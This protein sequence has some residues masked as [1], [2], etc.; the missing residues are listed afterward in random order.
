MLSGRR[1]ISLS[2]SDWFVDLVIDEKR[3]NNTSHLLCSRCVYDARPHLKHAPKP[4]L[5]CIIFSF[6]WLSKS[7]VWW[8]G[9]SPEGYGFSGKSKGLTHFFWIFRFLRQNKAFS[10][11]EQNQTYKNSL[12]LR[13][14]N[15]IQQKIL[16][17]GKTPYFFT[18]NPDF[19]WRQRT[20]KQKLY[21]E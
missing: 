10:A 18:Q 9:V 6:F 16:P 15:A 17:S 1:S 7:T 3:K 12:F 8:E 21:I 4:H 5:G 19:I 13:N 2:T 14:L 20:E 11:T